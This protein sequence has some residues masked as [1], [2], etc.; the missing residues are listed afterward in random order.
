MP[1]WLLTNY[2]RCASALFSCV[3]LHAVNSVEYVTE[4]VCVCVV[5]DMTE[6][7][8]VTHKPR[9]ASAYAVGRAKLAGL[10]TS[11]I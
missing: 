4:C 3:E 7:A 8:L 9:A 5:C 6:L 1:T 2:F 11:K 10:F